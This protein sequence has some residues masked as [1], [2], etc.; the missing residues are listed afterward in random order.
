[1]PTRNDPDRLA[2]LRRLMVLDTPKETAYD[3]LA[4][5]LATGLDV[6][7]TI[8]N[9]LDEHRDWFKA[10]AGLPQRES[11]A[12]TSMCEIFFD[13]DVPYV[14]VGD[15][16][17]DPRFSRHPLVVGEPHIRFYAA[18]RLMVQGQTI[19]TLCA[20]D[21]RPHRVT[22]AQVQEMLTLA[23]A[24]VALILKAAPPQPDTSA[25]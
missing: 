5:L 13:S 9:L 7:M 6:P 14:V 18:A 17:A 24:A 8:V 11:P 10:G 23:R 20:Y 21:L 3:D 2:A 1:M 19:G 15:T 16:A 22:A 12:A 25:A 4:R